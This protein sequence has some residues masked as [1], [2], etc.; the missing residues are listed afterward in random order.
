MAEQSTDVTDM[1]RDAGWHEGRAVG[2]ALSLDYMPLF[3]HAQSAMNEFGNLVVGKNGRGIQ[4]ATSKIIFNP[5]LVRHLKKTIQRYEAALQLRLYAL[6][7]IDD[8]HASLLIDEIGRVYVL[9]MMSLELHP[10]S[11]HFAEGLE[12]LLLGK[13][14]A[15]SD[16]ES[17]WSHAG[18]AVVLPLCSVTYNRW[19]RPVI[20]IHDSAS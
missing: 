9:S 13:R 6:G 16:I 1:L 17:I 14:L 11:S 19:K 7:E 10:L 15:N 8:G 3:P 4:C 5:D 18:G 2:S 20:T 12:L